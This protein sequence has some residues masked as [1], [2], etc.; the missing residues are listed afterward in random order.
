MDIQSSD[1][2]EKALLERL[3]NLIDRANKLLEKPELKHGAVN[4]WL[5]PLKAQ[6]KRIYGP[7]IDV[8][9][10][11][12]NITTNS[13][14]PPKLVLQQKLSQL[15]QFV[16]MQYHLLHRTFN[17]DCQG[18]VFIGHGRSHVWRELKDFLSDRLMLPWDEF[19]R[20]SV[21]G[22]TTFKRLSTMLGEASFA[23]LI[24]T[25]EDEQS[26]MTYNARQN[27]VHEVGLFQ[28]RLGPQKAIIL[29]EEGCNEFSNI[30]GLSEI[31]FPRNFI[32]ASFEKI[33][34]VLERENILQHN[35]AFS[36]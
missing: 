21:A 3:K 35:N 7:D 27:V 22:L 30:I 24:M 36:R 5:S 12:P 28:G 32:S 1:Q 29:L 4:F 20:E 14:L 33:R 6:L 34:Q 13:S 9:N 10:L 18:K 8:K 17:P 2:R 31:R 25:A 19:N 11:I 16:E 26:D 23:F 15:N